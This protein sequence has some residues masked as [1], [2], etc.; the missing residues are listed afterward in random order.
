MRKD[1]IEKR[2]LIE[3]W[4]LQSK[5]KA[6]MCRELKCKQD[7][8]NRCLK[9]MG[10]HYKGNKGNKGIYHNENMDRLTALEYASKSTYVKTSK[11]REK[12]I[13]DGI[14]EPRCE[15]CSRDTWEGKP[16]PLELHHVDGDRFN[17]SFENLKILC[18]NCH[19]Q[20]ENYGYS[21]RG[22]RKNPELWVCPSCGEY[23]CKESIRC[24]KCS[25]KARTKNP[26]EMAICPECGGGKSKHS[27]L[28]KKCD[29]ILRLGKRHKIKWP[30]LH[31]LKEAVERSS[32]LAVSKNLGVS[33]NAVRK[34]IKLRDPDYFSK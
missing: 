17:N 33:D 8:L 18:P 7:T 15:N 27:S 28:C 6:F 26:K 16:M 1:I 2:Q 3:G 12:L 13:E 34:H 25:Y 32:F 29:N 20:T 11:L 19:T 9:R 22:K 30:P 21:G 4:V 31:E 14:K 23:K 5:S 10:I 24:L